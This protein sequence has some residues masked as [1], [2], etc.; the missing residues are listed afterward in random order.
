MQNEREL[1][2]EEILAKMR[3]KREPAATRQQYPTHQPGCPDPADVMD[4]A[5]DEASP[6]VARC[7][8]EHLPTCDYCRACFAVYQKTLQDEEMIQEEPEPTPAGSMW[9][10]TATA[11]GE[12]T[13]LGFTRLA[14]DRALWP[15][16]LARLKPWLPFLLRRAGLAEDLAADLLSWVEQR[17]PDLGD[18]PFRHALAEWFAGFARSRGQSEPTW[19]PSALTLADLDQGAVDIETRSGP[20]EPPLVQRLK[21]AARRS[22][23]GGS[24]D[25]L[26]VELPDAAADPDFEE[27]RS[28]LFFQAQNRLEEGQRLFELV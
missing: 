14:Q 25:I 21:A 1:W 3:E 26:G 15:E 12:E 5:L 6:E 24:D 13:G 18:R 20:S 19:L 2:I 7:V 9:E 27:S 23:L 8:E 28:R 16:L 4:V 17:L 10:E 22:V 11:A